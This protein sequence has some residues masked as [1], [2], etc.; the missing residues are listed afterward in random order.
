MN[1]Y[2]RSHALRSFRRAHNLTQS[3]LAHLLGLKGTDHVA[4]MERGEREPSRDVLLKLKLIFGKPEDELVPS[5]VEEA[6]DAL[7]YAV[8][9]LRNRL[10]GR[11][12]HR[13]KRKM[14]L[15]DSIS[16]RLALRPHEAKQIPTI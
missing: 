7:W 4:K 12:D 16:S 15:L 9:E 1:Q 10:I 6:A 14:E 3:D 5:V 11:N 13:S 2:F 8:Q